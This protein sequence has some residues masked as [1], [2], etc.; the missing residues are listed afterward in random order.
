M[1]KLILKLAMK[2]L[3]M[4]MLDTLCKKNDEN[5]HLTQMEIG[6]ILQNEYDMSAD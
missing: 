3:P 5:Y 1:A 4:F 6:D 2:L